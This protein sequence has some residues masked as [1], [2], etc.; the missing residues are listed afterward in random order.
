MKIASKVYFFGMKAHYF[1]AEEIGFYVWQPVEH[2][3]IANGY[4]FTG[5]GIHLYLCNFF[6]G[7]NTAPIINNLISNHD[8]TN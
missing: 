1:L 3:R 2:C 8:S 6:K 5:H 7:Y 4:G